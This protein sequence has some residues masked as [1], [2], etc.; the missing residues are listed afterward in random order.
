VDISRIREDNVRKKFDSGI[1]ALDEFIHRYAR[2]NDRRGLSRTYVATA[3]GEFN[4]LGYVTIRA[5]EVACADLPP[6]EQKRLPRYPVPVLHV[7]RLAVDKG[8][9]GEGLGEQLLMYA[10]N[11]AVDAAEH[12]GVWGVEVIAKDEAARSF[13]ARYGFRAL[14]DDELHLYI[15]LKTLRK[16]FE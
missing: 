5:G 8:A 2:Q 15:S 9:R 7:A 4:V 6:E 12:M 16:A 13:Y 1:A 3:P 11:K 14:D 10:L